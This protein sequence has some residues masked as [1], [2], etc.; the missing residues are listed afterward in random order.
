MITKTI[1]AS[2][3]IYADG[4]EMTQM[5]KTQLQILLV[6][7]YIHGILHVQSQQDLIL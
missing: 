5:F 1:V 6:I 2:L 4:G 7:A 3:I